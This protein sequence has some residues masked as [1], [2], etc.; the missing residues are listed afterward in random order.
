MNHY[1]TTKNS[2]AVRIFPESVHCLEL[3]E[4]PEPPFLRE[5]IRSRG[6]CIPYG[7]LGFRCSGCSGGSPGGVP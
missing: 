1:R 5:L 6:M 3:H 2:E 7:L 4:P